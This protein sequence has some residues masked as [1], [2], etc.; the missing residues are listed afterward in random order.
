MTTAQ[1]IPSGPGTGVSGKKD[2]TKLND[3]NANATSLTSAPHLPNDHGL[4]SS[5]SLRSRLSLTAPMVAM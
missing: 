4:S 5:S 1:F 2:S 3:K